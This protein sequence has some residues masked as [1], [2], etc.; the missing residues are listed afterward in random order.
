[1][2]LPTL[3]AA[4]I[5]GIVQKVAA[6][7]GQQRQTYRPG[8]VPLSMGQQKAMRPFFPEPALD[9]T[10]LLVLAGRRVANP[11]FYSELIKMGF[12]A[13]S[14]PD[15]AHMAAITLVDTVVSHEAFTDRLLFHEL[16]HVIQ[17][18]KLGLEGFADK[19]VR[20]FLTGGSYDAIPLE[21]NAYELDARFAGAPTRA[22]S[23][24]DEVQR[25]INAGK[26]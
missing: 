4:Q 3:S 1:M 26:L 10:R 8:A 7:I 21:M 16:V 5:D 19:Y 20:G 22:F 9:A 23:V 2:P 15:F 24:A 12:E 14:L 13:T 17:Y 25:W 18:E 6:Y 11:P